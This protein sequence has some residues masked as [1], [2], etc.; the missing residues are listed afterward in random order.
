[1]H[2][3]ADKI[4]EGL[5]RIG[6]DFGRLGR[7]STEHNGDVDR[8]ILENSVCGRDRTEITASARKGH[9]WRRSDLAVLVDHLRRCVG[10]TAAGIKERRRPIGERD[11]GAGRSISLEVA[12]TIRDRLAHAVRID[13]GK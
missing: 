4:R 7:V 10:G 11:A 8:R 3:N 5:T 12:E 13:T 6:D 2:A 1:M 9:P